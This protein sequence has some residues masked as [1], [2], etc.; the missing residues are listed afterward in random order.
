M[1]DLS[2][3]QCMVPMNST[4]G[5][6]NGTTNELRQR[7]PVSLRNVAT[8]VMQMS[9]ESKRNLMTSRSDTSDTV[10]NLRHSSR[11]HSIHEPRVSSLQRPSPIHR[12][13]YSASQVPYYG[14]EATNTPK[15]LANTSIPLFAQYQGP[16]SSLMEHAQN[17]ETLF[18]KP[19]HDHYGDLPSF[20]Q[21]HGV[22]IGYHRRHKSSSS[23]IPEGDE[24]EEESDDE[25]SGYGSQDDVSGGD[26]RDNQHTAKNQP[27][28]ERGKHPQDTTPLLQIRAKPKRRV[29]RR[30]TR[31]VRAFM[32]VVKP[33][34]I[35]T[36]TKH[37]FSTTVLLFMAP[38]L[39]A[40]AFFY[41]FLDDPDLEFLPSS[42]KLSWYFLLAV[43]WSVTFT[44]AQITQ[45][46]LQ[47]LTI[48]TTVY[49]RIA[50]PLL[51]L[52]AMQS[53]GWPFLVSSWGIWNL[54]L[55]HG[56]TDFIRQWLYWTHIEMFSVEH[57]DGAGILASESILA[58]ELY[59]RI[60]AT[61]ILLGAAAALKQTFVALYL[62]RRM[63]QHYKG[64]L[65]QVMSQ[66]KLIM[67]VAELAAQTEEP[68]FQALLS[69]ANLG[70]E[71]GAT[72]A[73]PMVDRSKR[74]QL[75][76]TVPMF[77][78]DKKTKA[79]GAKKPSAEGLVE[80]NDDDDDEEEGGGTVG[81]GN[82]YN[83]EMQSNRG[84]AE[85][86]GIDAKMKWKWLKEQALND[87]YTM[88]F[89]AE[90][91]SLSDDRVPLGSKSGKGHNRD[92]STLT[93]KHTLNSIYPF[94]ERWPEP[95][96]KGR[97]NNIPNLHDILQFK[98]AMSF[99]ETEYPFSPSFGSCKTRKQ[100]VK[101]SA[102]VYRRLL[103]FT[104]D[105]QVLSFDVIGSLAFREDG[106]LDDNRAIALLRV[107]LPDNDDALPILAFVQSCD[108][109]YKRLRYLRAALSNSSKID[110]VLEDIFNVVFYSIL[111]VIFCE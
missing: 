31:P 104:P 59:G 74:H 24:G 40:A 87:R 98:K 16:T 50:G 52:V 103:R 88:N 54:V 6:N 41:Y 102:K 32:L 3:Q 5:A 12:R 100:A 105:E 21:D 90:D 37:F 106:S 35:W 47:V 15:E 94:L 36:N 70:K 99:M 25:V 51:A 97:K 91:S 34:E 23:S 65:E 72:A 26:N 66:V 43:R 84:G 14:E 30:L 82:T 44:L 111:A 63:L 93:T 77:A 57:T 2:G 42:A 53:M 33:D 58:S 76:E 81:A 95:E 83:R 89:V 73:L 20:K 7:K 18:Q 10:R 109:V 29:L 107:F 39:V 80:D 79:L 85:D 55:L 11:R 46:I 78:G 13:V 62:S 60:L 101:N 8:M 56:K 27:D 75:V 22:E 110:S 17:L 68:G 71:D 61:M 4:E 92:I 48:R 96:D 49:A 38:C 9:Q 108:L 28:V 19:R 67:E 86:S 69:K 1:A 64:Q 45:W